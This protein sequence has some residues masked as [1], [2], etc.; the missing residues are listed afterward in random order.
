ML[1]TI[2]LD[3]QYTKF[4]TS[5]PRAFFQNTSIASTG[6][7]LNVLEVASEMLLRFTEDDIALT[8]IKNYN[9]HG[10]RVYSHPTTALA[11][12]SICN[13][14]ASRFGKNVYPLC[15]VVSGDEVQINKK[16]SMGCKPFYISIANVKGALHTS[17]QNIECVGYS[18]DWVDTKVC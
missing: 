5:Y 2:F 6:F 9:E 10:E 11:F 7:H 4:S 16:G 13:N 3:Y 14:V 18:P 8:P 1:K 12:E 17:E 15:L